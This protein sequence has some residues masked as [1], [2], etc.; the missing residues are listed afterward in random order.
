MN[1]ISIDGDDIGR[2]ITSCYLRNDE[3]KLKSVSKSLKKSTSN[4]SNLLESLG[5][6]VLFCA[7]DGVAASIE[8]NID[9]M[10]LFESINSLA[11]AGISFSAGAG[12]S[13]REAYVALLAA[14]SNGKN[15]LCQ[16]ADI[17]MKGI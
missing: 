17:A 7:A 15:C 14:K 1:Y 10:E 6:D 4:I 11:P 12:N 16:Y 8:V 2:K 5:F 9:F 3:E 13:L